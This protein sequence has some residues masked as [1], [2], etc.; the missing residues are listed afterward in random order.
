MVFPILE[1]TPSGSYLTSGPAGMQVVNDKGVSVL[2]L[3]AILE[4]M[5]MICRQCVVGMV[6]ALVVVL[7]P[8]P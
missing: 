4:Q 3:W 6:Q 8:Q 7:R 1:Q 2:T 5:R